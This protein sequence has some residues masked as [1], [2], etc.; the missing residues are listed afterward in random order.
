MG[1]REDYRKAA[2]FCALSCALAWGLISAFTGVG[3]QWRGVATVL[4]GLPLMYVPFVSAVIVQKLVWRRGLWSQVGFAFRWNR[5]IVVAW[6]AM[7]VLALAATGVALLFPGVEYT[8]DSAGMF[9]RFGDMMTPEQVAQMKAQIAEMSVHPFWLTLASSLTFGLVITALATFGEEAGWRG[10]LLKQLAYLGFWR[11]SLLIGFVWG[12]WH[13][14]VILA[15]HNYPHH[16]VAGVFLMIAFCVAASPL[17]AYVTLRSRTPLAAVILHAGVN[18][19]AGLSLMLVRGHELYVGV[20][21]LAGLVVLSVANVVL[22][23]HDRYVAAHPAWYLMDTLATDGWHA[24]RSG[25]L[26]PPSATPD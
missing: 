14:P 7:P 9:E 18:S 3:G 24:L 1:M 12:V 13:F 2:L 23:L 25:R 11:S 26:E 10:Y 19:S 20:M 4:V 6:L 17:H 5:W 8:P 22:Y 15:G 21:G 16:P